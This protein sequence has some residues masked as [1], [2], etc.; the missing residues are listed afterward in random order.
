MKSPQMIKTGQN[1]IPFVIK[2]LGE[3]GPEGNVVNGQHHAG[4]RMEHPPRP[5]GKAT[6]SHPFAGAQS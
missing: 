5:G 4:G 3:P 6:P 2:T 1:S